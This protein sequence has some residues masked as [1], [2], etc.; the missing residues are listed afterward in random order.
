MF[1]EYIPL[2]ETFPALYRWVGMSGASPGMGPASFAVKGR[3][4]CPNICFETM[5][6]HVIGTQLRDLRKSREVADILINL[7]ND[8]WFWGSTIL[9]MHFQAGIFRAIESRR[10]LV[11]AANT[12][13]TAWIDG[14]G[15]VLGQLPRRQPGVLMAGVELDGRE[16]RYARWG[17]GPL[18]GLV[19]AGYGWLAWRG[20]KSARHQAN[21][22]QTPQFTKFNKC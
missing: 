20:R 12:G 3:K 1:G 16:S 10:P 19:I 5:V 18:T 11:V 2:G 6:P 13:I 22:S 14:S 21:P 9:D 8:G 17:D 15:R 4:L 7:T